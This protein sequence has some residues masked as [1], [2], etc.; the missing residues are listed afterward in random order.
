MKYDNVIVMATGPGPEGVWEDAM[1]VRDSDTIQVWV[2]TEGGGVELDETFTGADR[3]L[4]QGSKQVFTSTSGVITD[5]DGDVYDTIQ[6]I[7]IRKC[8][9]CGG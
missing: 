1:V 8:G 5:S 4:P 9:R 7:P 2:R 3:Y 6:I